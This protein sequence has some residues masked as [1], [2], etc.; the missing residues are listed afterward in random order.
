MNAPRDLA[1]AQTGARAFARLATPAPALAGEAALRDLCDVS[2]WEDSIRRSRMRREAAERHL[3][4]GPVTGKRLAVP[5]A[6]LAAGLL[7][8]D[9]VVS[10]DGNGMAA[11]LPSAEHANAAAVTKHAGAGAQHTKRTT[12]AAHASKKPTAAG[13][14]PH[15]AGLSPAARPL[16]HEIAPKRVRPAKTRVGDELSRGDHGPAVAA[17][18]RQLGVP[19]DGFFGPHTLAAVR[20]LQKRRELTVDGRVGPAT[21]HALRTTDHAAKPHHSAAGARVHGDGVRA[22]QQALGISAD[23]VFGRQTAAAVRT[24]QRKHGL[25]ADGVVGP[26]TWQALGVKGAHSILRRHHPAKHSGAHHARAHHQAHSH[27]GTSI[28]DLQR[29]LGVPVDGDFGPQTARAVRAFQRKHGLQADGIVGP[30]TWAALGVK[31]AHHI[32]R[33]PAARHHSGG[34]HRSRG[35]GGGG[36]MPSAVSRAIAA[37]NAIATKPYRYGGGHGSFNDSGYDCSG[38]VSYVLHGAGLLSSPLDSTALESYGAPGPGRYITIYAN[39]GHAFMTINGRRFDTGYGGEGNR[40][41]SGSRPTSGFVVRHP[42]GL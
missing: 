11:G 19:A 7:V 21:W 8:R 34:G 14:H 36:G 16:P 37:A 3:S 35:G 15:A 22:L 33:P 41:A 27:G 1:R 23:G 20:Q 31:G 5:M 12:A 9:A 28:S 40:W 32:L 25:K 13:A 18:Q 30:A 42:P 29:L 10:D 24:F 2:V 4:F 38:S 6:M 39:S 26:A 17:M